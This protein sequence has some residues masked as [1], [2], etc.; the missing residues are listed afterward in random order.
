MPYKTSNCRENSLTEYI[1]A[2]FLRTSI[3][4]SHQ[5]AIAGRLNRFPV[6][7]VSGQAARQPYIHPNDNFFQAGELYRRVMTVEDK[8]HLIGNI[9]THLCNV[10]K[11]IQQRQAAIFYKADNEYGA[12]VAEGLKL[13]VKK[14]KQLAEMSQEERAKATA[15]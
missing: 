10:L 9:T 7:E 2:P 11:R 5:F 13:D 15:K 8:E 3:H 4:I 12:R 1:S 14:V 6:F